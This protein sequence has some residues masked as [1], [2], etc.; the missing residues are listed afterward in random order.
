MTA[1]LTRFAEQTDEYIFGVVVGFKTLPRGGTQNKIQSLVCEPLRFITFSVRLFTDS[2]LLLGEIWAQAFDFIPNSFQI[3]VV[4][5]SEFLQG[6]FPRDTVRVQFGVGVPQLGQSPVVGDESQGSPL[7]IRQNWFPTR[8]GS[9]WIVEIASVIYLLCIMLRIIWIITLQSI[10]I[11]T[12]NWER[13]TQESRHKRVPS[14][15]LIPKN[16]YVYQKKFEDSAN[17]MVP[18]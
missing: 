11:I 4:F 6:L 16:Q 15:F 5:V 14:I 12:L 2:V 8:H 1:Y 18:H 13:F 7:E 17:L 9:G 3:Q 10:I